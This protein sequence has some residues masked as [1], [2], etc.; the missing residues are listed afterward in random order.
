MSSLGTG[1][2]ET[3][4]FERDNEDDGTGQL[5]PLGCMV[6]Q[7]STVPAHFCYCD[8]DCTEGKVPYN[9]LLSIAMYRYFP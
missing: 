5:D 1:F 9:V 7:K 4:S 3:E 2:R 8:G 6:H